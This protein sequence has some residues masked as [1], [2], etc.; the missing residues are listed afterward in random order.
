[1]TNERRC[2]DVYVATLARMRS[3]QSMTWS[4]DTS[5]K[6]ELP[7]HFI[8]FTNSYRTVVTLPGPSAAIQGSM[9]PPFPRL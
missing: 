5:P 3:S 7:C 4:G 9:Q 6:S 1:M 8:V 2:H